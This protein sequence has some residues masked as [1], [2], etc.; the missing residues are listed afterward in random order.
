M[1]TRQSVKISTEAGVAEWQTRKFQKLVE[2]T[3]RGGSTPLLGT[4]L[5]NSL[6]APKH[7]MESREQ[8]DK[9]FT[10]SLSKEEVALLLQNVDGDS[11][12]KLFGDQRIDSKLG[13]T[14]TFDN[15][16]TGRNL[17]AF[18]KKCALKSGIRINTISFS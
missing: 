2:I 9:G 3:L 13:A 12:V 1:S 15:T 16:T 8:I 10:H 7:Y 11:L 14:F 5:V 4:S 6:T 18:L 17:T